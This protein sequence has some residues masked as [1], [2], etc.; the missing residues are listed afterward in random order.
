MITKLRERMVGLTSRESGFTLIELMIVI[1]V[2]GILAGIAVPRIT[3]V[4]DDA[5][6][7]ALKQTATSVRNTMEMYYAQEGQYPNLSSVSDSESLSEL[8]GDNFDLNDVNIKKAEDNSGENDSDSDRSEYSITIQDAEADSDY[9]IT[10]TQDGIGDISDSD[11]ETS[12]SD[13][14]DTDGDSTDSE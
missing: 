8:L 9:E 12:G 3:G 13:S 10:I 5:K 14:E 1:A 11:S 6:R 2:L 4:Q 7:N